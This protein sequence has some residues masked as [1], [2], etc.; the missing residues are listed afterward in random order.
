M[1]LIVDDKKENILSL[2]ALLAQYNYPVDSAS[3]GEEA[4]KKILKKNYHLIILDVQMPGMDGFEVAETIS[5]YSK[6]ED[7]PL[8]FVSAVN[9]DK[10]FIAKGYSSGAIDYITKP[11]DPD[12]FLLKVNTLYNLYEQK[13]KLTEMQAKLKSEITFREKA[14]YEANEKAKELRS[15]LESIPQIAFTT[16]AN[17]E[18]EYHNTQWMN[19][20]DEASG[21]LLIHPDDGILTDELKKMAAGKNPLEMEL[22][23]K[24]P[25]DKEYRYHLLKVLPVQENGSITKWTGTFTEI[26]EQKQAVK[27]K[28]EFISMASHE[29]KTPLTSIRGY[30]QLLERKIEDESLKQY[31][32]RTVVQ[33]KKLDRLVGD[34]LDISKI[35]NGK[36]ILD[37]R[38]FNFGKMLNATIRMVKE[39]YP[40]YTIE[41]DGEADVTV[42]GDDVRMEQVLI[43]FL[44][45]AIK[46]APHSKI[47]RIETIVN[48]QG[49]L[50]VRVIDFGVGIHQKDLKS[51]FEKFYRTEE[52]LVNFQG[53]GLGLYICADILSR[54]NCE[55][56]VESELG[57]GSTFHFSMPIKQ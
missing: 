56:G 12:I 31:I 36:L 33:I 17:G 50:D 8:I 30:V 47:I 27:K 40:D 49:K 52:S 21:E 39:T 14:Q 1:I 42:H 45:N 57:R 23:L 2:K 19:Y 46:Y 20:A 9:T 35:E 13:R 41:Y 26:D 11:I 44:S 55:Y 10:K 51:I 54:H 28:D 25:A 43:N 16:R 3:S 29:L 48:A 5:G 34:L 37:K 53:L 38:D 18:I 7:V 22:R 32:D 24:K 6:V 15:I 4:L